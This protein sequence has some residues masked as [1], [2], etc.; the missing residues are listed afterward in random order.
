MTKSSVNSLDLLKLVMSFGIVAI[1]SRFLNAYIYPTVRLAVPAFFVLTGYFAFSK[2]D[3]AQ[4]GEKQGQI[5]KAI[6]KRN[7]LLYGSWT[8]LLFPAIYYM[9]GF[10]AQGWTKGIPAMLVNCLRGVSFTGSWYLL[11]CMIALGI[12]FVLSRYF[13]NWHLILVSMP[14]YVFA[15]LCSEL[16]EVVFGIPLLNQISEIHGAVFGAPCLSFPIA[17]LYIALGK[18]MVRKET[19]KRKKEYYFVKFLLCYFLLHCEFFF[20]EN[21]ITSAVKRDCYFMLA[22][23]AYFLVMFIQSIRIQ[24]P[25]AREMRK[26]STI[27]YC[28]HG[29]VLAAVGKIITMFYV[30]DVLNIWLFSGTIG[31]C[32]LLSAFLIGLEKRVGFRFIKYLY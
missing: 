11:A 12:V 10:Y 5:V 16:P 30:P 20:V 6:I 13:D 2:I 24:V 8:L 3:A 28:S 26:T 17:V 22:P 4:C 18:Y 31:A 32:L 7:F 21:N 29:V 15:T 25:Y 23:T 1:H 27:I 19:G 9:R 14:F